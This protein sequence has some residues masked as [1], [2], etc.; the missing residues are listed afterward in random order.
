L[1]DLVKDSK[2]STALHPQKIGVWCA[3]SRRR[4]IVPLLFKTTIIAK[5]YQELIQQFIAL[6]EVDGRNRWFHQDSSTAHTAAATM[7]ILHEFFSRKLI[8]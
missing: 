1:I 2:F 6:L 7:E 4:I 8:F 5:A 3:I